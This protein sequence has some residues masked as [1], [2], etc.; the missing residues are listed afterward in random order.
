MDD[1]SVRPVQ[2]IASETSLLPGDFPYFSYKGT[3]PFAGRF[4]PVVPG[5]FNLL[6]LFPFG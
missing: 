2:L 3:R 1:R 4:L 6:G 5:V